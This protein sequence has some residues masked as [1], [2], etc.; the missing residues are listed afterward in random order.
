MILGM[1]NKVDIT[2]SQIFAL[3]VVIL[4]GLRV[5]AQF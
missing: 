4:F 5:L 2:G 3:A 1:K